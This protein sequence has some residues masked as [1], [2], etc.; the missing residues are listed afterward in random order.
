MA[1][2]IYPTNGPVGRCASCRIIVRRSWCCTKLDPEMCVDIQRPRLWRP[3][4]GLRSVYTKVPG[5][6]EREE[7]LHLVCCLAILPTEGRWQSNNSALAERGV[8]SRPIARDVFHHRRSTSMTALVV[9]V[10]I[11]LVIVYQFVVLMP[12]AWLKATILCSIWQLEFVLPTAHAAYWP[13][14]AQR[15][16]RNTNIS[17][18]VAHADL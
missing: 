9:I 2:I 4:E 11:S 16:S 7:F 15:N 14:I 3:T 8:T 1:T 12:G 5:L 18:S 13:N 10:V 6:P 17:V